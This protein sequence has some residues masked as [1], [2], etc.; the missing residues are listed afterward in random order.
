MS[1]KNQ[2]IHIHI[3]WIHDHT[4]PPV[5]PFLTREIFILYDSWSWFVTRSKVISRHLYILFGSK[6]HVK[7]N[8]EYIIVTRIFVIVNNKEGGI[9]IGT[10]RRKI[11]KV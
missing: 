7:I 10:R 8:S 6:S 1:I 3:D 11:T 5:F 2:N 4:H 9:W